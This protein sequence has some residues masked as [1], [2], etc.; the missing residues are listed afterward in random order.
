MKKVSILFLANSFADDTIEYMPRIAKEYGYDLDVF[1]LY[2]GGCEVQRHIDN[3]KSH[4]KA[5]ELR[6]FNK[7]QDYWETEYEVA[8]NDFI[9]S[10]HWDYIVLQQSSWYSGL[11]DGL[12]DVN[13]LLKMV[14]ELAN[15]DVKFVWNMTWA[16]PKYS[17]IE[18]FIKEF[19]RDQ[20]KM[21]RAIVE[22][23]KSVI[24]PIKDF[25]KI[26]PNGTALMNARRYIKDELLHRDDFHLSYQPGRYLAAMTAVSTI[27][28]V[29]L[30]NLKYM[31][32]EH[33]DE[34]MKQVLIKSA[35]LAVQSP[36]EES[37]Y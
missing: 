30:T 19:G 3:L 15:K 18:I 21:Y 13:V 34:A 5:Y 27:L 20:N 23:V 11:K 16:Y 1:N 12:K 32:N 10:R 8:S 6:V 17:D 7:E 37:E 2:I 31:P 36:L 24:L 33:V 4:A 25:V 35:K 29:D 22:N 28:G 9:A 14:K 26:I